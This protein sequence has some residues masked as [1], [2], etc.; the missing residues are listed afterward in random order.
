MSSLPDIQLIFVSGMLDPEIWKHQEKY[1]SRSCRIETVGGQ[2]FNSLCEELED[3]LDNCDNAVVVGAE[4]GNHAVKALEGHESVMSTVFTGLFEALPEIKD[5]RKYKLIRRSLSK[6][7]I[8]KKAFF[9]D[10]TDYRL[11][12]EFTRSFKIPSYDLYQT[13]SDLSLDVPLKN[14]LVIYNQDCRFSS[15]DKVESL[16]SNSQIALL[17][18]GTFSFYEK[19]QEF[20]KALHDYLQG[21]KSFLEKR[22]LVKAASENRS[23]KDFNKLEVER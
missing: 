7:K 5:E 8:F 9:K 16:K 19:P 15:M 4:K 11:V 1:F 22:E 21:K 12:K 10:K 20:N 3:M 18:A 2:N 17:D 6:P 13:Y 14:S 23:L